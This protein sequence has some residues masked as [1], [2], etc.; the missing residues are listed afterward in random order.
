MKRLISLLLCASF[1]ATPAYCSYNP[2]YLAAQRELK[3]LDLIKKKPYCGERQSYMFGDWDCL[4]EELEN[5][6][7]LFSST[8][9]CEVLGNPTGGMKQG[10]RYDHSMGWDVN[11][12]LEKFVGMIGTQFHISG[13]WRAGQDLSKATIGNDLTVSNIYG[14]QQ[15][16]FYFLYLEKNLLDKRL[17]VRIGRIAAGDDFATSPLYGIYVSNAV[18]GVPISMPINMFFSVYPTATWGARAKYNI[19]ED[20]YIFSGIYDGDAAVA[21]NDMYGFDFSLRLKE[22]LAFAQELAYA[23]EKGVGPSCLPGHYKGGIYY[24]GATCRDLYSDINGDS[25]AVTQLDRKKHIGNYNVY[26]MADQMIY[27]EKGTKD[28]GL[29]ALAVATVGPDSINK[30]PFFLMGGLIYKGLVP[31]RDSDLTAVQMAYAKYSDKLKESEQSVG[32][33]PQQYEIAL[34]FTHRIN[35]TKWF[36]VQPD[37]QYIIQPGGTGN[38][39]DALVLGFQLGLTF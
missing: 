8:Y 9:T 12:D 2:S 26:V 4:R 35:I 17:N 10:A 32:S 21:R 30:F 19:N 39:D 20:F 18:N 27:R 38:I 1:F 15:F 29:T 34:E 13:L 23:P 7:V 24:N 33:S 11:F 22:G 36:Y 3:K 14:N 25:Y 5:E 28:D 31:G 16:R 37:I 6:G